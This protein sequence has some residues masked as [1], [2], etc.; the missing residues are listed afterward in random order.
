[1]LAAAS[2]GLELLELN[3]G[4]LQGLFDTADLAHCGHCI[5]IIQGR[6]A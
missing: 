6:Q 4:A 1:L 5:A 2:G 3:N